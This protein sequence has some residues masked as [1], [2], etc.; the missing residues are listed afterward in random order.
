[1]KYISIDIETTGLNPL[2]NDIL[3]IGAYIEDTETQ[4]PRNQLPTFHAYIWKENYRGNA[5][6]L[7]MNHH[8]LKKILELK[9]RS[10]WS[11]LSEPEYVSSRFY[12]FLNYHK[13]LWSKEQFNGGDGPFMIAGKNVA[14]FDLPFLNQLPNWGRLKFHR[15]V[16]DPAIL[17]F[18]PMKDE[19]P[20]DLKT[21]KQRVGLP[22]LVTHAAL[23]D[24]WDV[25]SLIRRKFPS[26]AI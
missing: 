22:E 19:V 16:L 7:Q 18:D 24:A 26:Y 11:V 17:Y 2:E 9:E 10:D 20:P 5:F 15:R 21:C 14:G 3:E 4:L 1:M 25:I 8:I 23:D 12:Q 6:A 13:D